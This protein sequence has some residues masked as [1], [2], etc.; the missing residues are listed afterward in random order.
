MDRTG[1]SEIDVRALPDD[2]TVLQGDAADA[3][4][5]LD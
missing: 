1:V 5:P 3:G 4:T 2:D